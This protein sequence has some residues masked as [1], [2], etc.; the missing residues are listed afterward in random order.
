M[1][2]SR[3]INENI[4]T[5]V[6]EDLSEFVNAEEVGKNILDEVVNEKS[7]ARP[8]ITVDAE[9]LSQSIPEPKFTAPP[10]DF[11]KPPVEEKPKEKREPLNPDMKDLPK[12]DKQMASEVL[13]EMILDMYSLLHVG[14]NRALMVSEGRLIKMQKEGE[15]KLDAEIEY[16]YGKKMKAYE[17][18]QEY[19]KQAETALSVSEEFKEE[20]RPVLKKVL[21]DR[22]LGMT[23]EQQLGYL[24]AKDIAGKG[25][26]AFSIRAQ[27]KQTIE[28][29]KE[30]SLR[31]APTPSTP[32]MPSNDNNTQEQATNQKESVVE[33]VST[34]PLYE[35]PIEVK[36]E[37]SGARGEKPSTIIIK[38]DIPPRGKRGAKKKK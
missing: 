32:P 25:I 28:V 17:F 6:G 5:E 20:V 29:I 2:N 9:K 18:F 27:L 1:A 12:K 30:A 3:E 11:S 35:E 16:D 21:E 34:D 38:A 26:I 24:F 14:A 23:P 36:T 15:I 37:T 13:G 4:P 7:Y 8:N 33:P 22:G 19:N 10:V 31:T